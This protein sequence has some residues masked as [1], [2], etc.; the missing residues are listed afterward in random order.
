VR[1]PLLLDTAAYPQISFASTRLGDDGD[2]WVLRGALPA[3]GQ[4]HRWS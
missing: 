4:T 2:R 1:Y 3:R